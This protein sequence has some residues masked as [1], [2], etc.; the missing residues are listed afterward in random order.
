MAGGSSSA[1]GFAR[2]GTGAERRVQRRA[3]R[4]EKTVGDERPKG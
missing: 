1:D 2:R 3:Q 4:A